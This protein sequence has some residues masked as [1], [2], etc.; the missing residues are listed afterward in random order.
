MIRIREILHPEQILLGFKAL[1]RGEAVLRTAQLLL[2]DPRMADWREFYRLLT[3]Q[4]TKEKTNL[5]FGL[6]LPHAR[7]DAVTEMVTAFSRLARPIPEEG[8]LVHFICV[9][10]IPKSFDADYLRMV[11][12]LMRVFR[13]ESSRQ[14][15]LTAKEPA[16]VLD[17]LEDQETLLVN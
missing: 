8:G 14:E 7:T 2:R 5:G 9:V 3:K 12:L 15:L 4:E 16:N 11:G 10:G 17:I 6:I 13:E 1:T